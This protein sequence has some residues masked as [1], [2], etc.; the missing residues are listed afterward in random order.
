MAAKPF[1]SEEWKKIN[2]TLKED[3]AK[4]GMPERRYGSVVLGAFNIRKLGSTKKRNETTWK[5]LAHVCAQ[6]DLLAIQEIL[7]DLSGLKHLM[8]LLGPEFGLII[9]DTTGAFPS[10]EGLA[11]RLGFVYNLR[12][13]QRTEIATDITYDRTRVLKTLALNR[14]DIVPVMNLYGEYLESI[15]A[16]EDGGKQ[17]PKPKAP[18][19][20]K[21]R[22]PAFLTFIRQPFC[23]GFKISGHSGT[24][25]YE[26]L[27][28]N[29]HLNYGDPKHDPKQEFYALMDWIVAR[30]GQE[31]KPYHENFVLLGDLNL[32]FDDPDADKKRL[33]EDIKALNNV[34]EQGVSVNFPFL[35]IHPKHNEVFRT[36]ARK[37]QTYDQIGLFTRDDRLPTHEANET[38]M[39]QNL[40]GP[41]YG[42]FNFVDLFQKALS[43]PDS[44]LKDLFGRFEH[45]VSDH[46]PLWL[47]LPLP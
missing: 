42:V 2:E 30:A 47:R 14:E 24:K 26:F 36:N 35:D 27:T 45:K 20:S 17:G 10:K 3:P 5:F 18:S 40:V 1:T 28:V 33:G 41:D 34:T 32:D 8:E 37:T 38:V 46:M 44:G 16:W 12:L 4:F 22:M 43:V 21:L 9:S 29:A 13:V 6:F 31:G 39:G 19:K 11:E 25:P 23:V 15:R 7:D